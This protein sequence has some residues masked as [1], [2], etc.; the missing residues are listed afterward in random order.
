MAIKTYVLLEHM[1]P[2]NASIFRRV[3]KT[4]RQQ[5]DKLP[6][7]RPYLQVNAYIAKEKKNK[8]IRYK[9]SADSIYQD[10]QIKQGIPAN[11]RF[12]TTERALPTFRNSVLV[13]KDETLQTYL[14][15]YPGFEGNENTSPVVRRKEYRLYDKSADTKRENS[16]MR[17]RIKAANKI[18]EMDLEAT[19]EMLY[20]FYGSS[21]QPSDDLDENVN[22]LIKELDENDQAIPEI[23]K[24]AVTTDDAATILIGKALSAGI[25]SFTEK[26]GQVSK[27]KGQKWIDV[28]AISN[29]Y[30]LEERKRHF[31]EFITSDAGK[32]LWDDIEKD[33]AKAGKAE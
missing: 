33:V 14:E 9:E 13:T 5:L 4:Q 15:A 16:E 25:L 28:R 24:E 23:L 8:T 2:S 1:N 10:E 29:E 21:Y 27:K 6:V 31:A 3:N 20:R 22:I 17:D 19:K 7:Y 11:E 18:M 32:T 12:T 30:P 26:E